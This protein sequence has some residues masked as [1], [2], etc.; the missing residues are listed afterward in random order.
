MTPISPSTV[1]DYYMSPYAIIFM[2][3]ALGDA[4]TL[5][6]SVYANAKVVVFRRDAIGYNPDNNYRQ[7]TIVAYNT[8][9]DDSLARYCHLAVS[10][11]GDFATIV[12]PS[13]RLD[14]FGREISEDG[15]TYTASDGKTYIRNEEGLYVDSEGKEAEN[16]EDEDQNNW[17]IFLGKITSSENGAR[18]WDNTYPL[19]TGNLDTDQY[20][21]DV[22][23]G[24]WEKMF[25]LNELTNLIEQKLPFAKIILGATKKVVQDIWRRAELNKE[26]SYVEDGDVNEAEGEEQTETED[27]KVIPSVSFL[28]GGYISKLRDSEVKAV[29]KFLKYIDFGQFV[30]GMVGGS[31]GRIDSEGNA[32]VQNL[33]VWKSMKVMELIINRLR[34]MAGDF[35]FA[36]TRKVTKV[37][38]I[39]YEQGHDGS[40]EGDELYGIYKLTLDKDTDFDFHA[41]HD[42]DIVY[43]IV[44]TIPIGG[45]DYHTGFYHIASVDT[46]DNSVTVFLYHDD[47]LGGTRNHIPMADFNIAHRGHVDGTKEERLSQWLLSSTEGRITFLDNLTQPLVSQRNYAAY[48][49]KFLSSLDYGRDLPIRDNDTVVFAR[50]LLAENLYMVDYNGEVVVQQPERGEWSLETAMSDKPYRCVY[51]DEVEHVNDLPDKRHTLL[52]QDKVTHLGSSWICIKDK[53]T[54][55]PWVDSSEW[56]CVNGNNTVQIE[57]HSSAGQMF[58]QGRVDT[59]LYVRLLYNGNDITG[60]V[61]GMELRSLRWTRETGNAAEDAAWNDSHET[62]RSGL[63]VRIVQDTSR[64][65]LGTAFFSERRTAR[66]TFTLELPVAGSLGTVSYSETVTIK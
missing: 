61:A 59:E 38:L 45:T 57:V 41:F 17:Y 5:S 27:D 54:Q 9:F 7:W 30:S 14:L 62:T 25:Y 16:I 39:G 48:I 42:G 11:T 32:E 29:L 51:T 65:D 60:K 33:C 50:H 19:L 46:D 20:R 10:K 4:D 36:E 56:K 21:N 3:N 53:T 18:S 34:A 13:C 47:D 31:G 52:T 15:M 23:V 40:T 44:N 49:G 24:A 43:Q 64:F 35:V 58:R 63:G 28:R 66:F 26:V 8:H 12:Y 55:E 2:L 37:E 22:N 1:N 6:V